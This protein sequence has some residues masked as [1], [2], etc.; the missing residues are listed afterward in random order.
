MDATTMRAVVAYISELRR[1]RDY[2]RAIERS[3]DCGE[4][5]TEGDRSQRHWSGDAGCST[6]YTG[7]NRNNI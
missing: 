4:E 5:I 6:D 1:D 3:R 7:Q 2:H